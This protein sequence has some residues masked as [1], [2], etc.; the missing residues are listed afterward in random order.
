MSPL[1]A[2][3]GLEK[4]VKALYINSLF[5][6]F[7]CSRWCPFPRRTMLNFGTR[8]SLSRHFDVLVFDAYSKWIFSGSSCRNQG[9]CNGMASRRCACT[10]ALFCRFPG[11]T[12]RHKI[13]MR[14]ALFWDGLFHDAFF[15]QIYICSSLSSLELGSDTLFLILLPLP[16]FG[17]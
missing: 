4:E 5:H 15:S 7:L 6:R 10:R 13:C 12:S 14:T 2:P 3:I 16:K 11:K 9:T 8:L 17:R 1:L